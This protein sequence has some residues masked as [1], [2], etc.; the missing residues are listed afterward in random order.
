MYIKITPPDFEKYKIFH[1]LISIDLVIWIIISYE[2]V[3]LDSYKLYLKETSKI[4]IIY[5]ISFIY[6]LNMMKE[7]LSSTEFLK[8]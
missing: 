7:Y 6:P 1:S 2:N 4:L 8:D 3:Q 5:K